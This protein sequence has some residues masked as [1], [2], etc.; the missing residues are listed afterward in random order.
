MDEL[1]IWQAF[2][3][4]LFATALSISRAGSNPTLNE[5]AN[6]NTLNLFEPTRFTYLAPLLFPTTTLTGVAVALLIPA[7]VGTALAVITTAPLIEGRQLQVATIL[8]AEPV[9]NLFL[10]PLIVTFL[11]LKVTLDATETFAV[12]VT[13][14]LKVALPPKASELKDEVSTTSVTVIVIACVPALAAVSVAVRVIS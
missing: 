11:A 1:P 2:S 13:T 8:G 6:K 9:V 7:P 14:C 3:I 10:H 4:T 12:I 5:S